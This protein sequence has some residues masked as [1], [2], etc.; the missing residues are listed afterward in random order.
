MPATDFLP[1]DQVMVQGNHLITFLFERT[2]FGQRVAYC[3][4][5][6]GDPRTKCRVDADKLKPM[7]AKPCRKS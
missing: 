7:S 2:E 1:G 5:F 4:Y 3:E 6:V